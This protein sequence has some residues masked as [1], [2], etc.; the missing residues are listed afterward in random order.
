MFLPKPSF[1]WTSL[2]SSDNPIFIPRLSPVVTIPTYPLTLSFHLTCPVLPT[3]HPLLFLL[4]ILH[5]GNKDPISSF[6]HHG[7]GFHRFLVHK[8]FTVIQE[9]SH[10]RS[11]TWTLSQLDP[12]QSIV[13]VDRRPLYQGP[14][15]PL[16]FT[17]PVHLLLYL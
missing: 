17:F 13:S 16:Y 6:D 5:W 10:N 7:K 15:I 1:L 3:L 2:H 9:V 11:F 8:M 14:F 4:L 12:Y